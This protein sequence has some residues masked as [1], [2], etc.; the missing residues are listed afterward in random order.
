MSPEGKRDMIT[1]LAQEYPVMVVCQVLE[2]ARSTY[3]YQER[4]KDDDEVKEAI[5]EVV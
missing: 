1:K 5:K 3:Y 4:Q 2:T